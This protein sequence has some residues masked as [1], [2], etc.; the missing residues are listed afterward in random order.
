MQ[1]RAALMGKT[2]ANETSA[3]LREAWRPSA[4]RWPQAK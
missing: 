3:V 1:F 2:S 4:I